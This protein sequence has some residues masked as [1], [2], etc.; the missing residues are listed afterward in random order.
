MTTA[1]VIYIWFAGFCVGYGLKA[2]IVDRKLKKILHDLQKD[3]E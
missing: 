3:R 2:I 1:M